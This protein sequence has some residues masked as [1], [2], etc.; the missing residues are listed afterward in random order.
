ME[1]EFICQYRNLSDDGRVLIHPT[2]LA[3]DAQNLVFVG[4]SNDDEIAVLDSTNNGICLGFIS[5][6]GLRSAYSLHLDRQGNLYISDFSAGKIFI[7]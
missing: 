1:G 7:I 5:C 6:P 3:I 4:S 2:S